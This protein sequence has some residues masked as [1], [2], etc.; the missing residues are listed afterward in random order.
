MLKKEQGFAHLLIVLVVGLSVLVLVSSLIPINRYYNDGKS[1]VA[2]VS[3]TVGGNSDIGSSANS[4]QIKISSDSGQ[5]ALVDKRVGALST[6]PISVNPK[7]N[8]VTVNTPAGS[9]VVAVLPQKAVDNLLASKV[10]DYVVGEKVNNS[11]GSIP[12]LVKLETKNGVLGYK[13][14]GTRTCKVLGFIPLKTAVEAF[15]SA[16]N[17]QV[18]ESNQS[19]LGRIL[20]KISL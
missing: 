1:N 6:Y 13:I 10:M 8:E 20:S 11:L 9:K 14:S 2:G 12:S 18:V 19:L 5:T 3:T 7:T 4:S 16:E 17:G 15:V